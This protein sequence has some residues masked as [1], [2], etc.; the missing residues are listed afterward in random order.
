[1]EFKCSL[2]S[3]FSIV[4]FWSF[5]SF[6]LV[7]LIFWNARYLTLYLKKD[8]MTEF[9]LCLTL[10]YRYRILSE[11]WLWLSCSFNNEI[12]L[13][14]FTQVGKLRLN[15]YLAWWRWSILLKQDNTC[16]CGHNALTASIPIG[17]VLMAVYF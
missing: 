3:I 13:D 16:Q 15:N 4:V 12:N 2:Y 5:Y 7:E 17:W 11:W 6:W 10:V 1:V 9:F 8:F 14:Y